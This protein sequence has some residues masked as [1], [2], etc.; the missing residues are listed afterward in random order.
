MLELK[1]EMEREKYLLRKILYKYIPKELLER[2]KHGFGVPIEEWFKKEL[3][4]FYLEYLNKE[5]IKKR[6]FSIQI[7]L[8]NCFKIT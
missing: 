3:K 8:K 7:M 1:N 6:E 2:P 4:E 5:R